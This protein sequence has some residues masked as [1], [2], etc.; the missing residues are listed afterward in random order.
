MT[1]NDAQHR[2]LILEQFTRQAI[3]F[4]EMPAHSNDAA[5]RL[6]IELAGDKDVFEL[7]WNNQEIAARLGTVREIVS[8]TLSRMAHEG[9]IAIDGRQVTILD[10]SRL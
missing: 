3:P 4:S 9:A 2:R 10:R 8:R 5:N 6:L 1:D 7:E